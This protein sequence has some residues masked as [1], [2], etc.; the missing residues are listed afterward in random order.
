MLSRGEMDRIH[1][2]SIRILH[3]TGAIVRSADA[4]GLLRNAGN[5]V[6]EKEMRVF[7]EE[8]LIK[9]ALTSAPREIVLGAR[10]PKHDLRV[11]NDGFPY[12]STDGFAVQIRDSETFERRPSIREDLKKWATVTDALDAIDVLWPSIGA[13]DLPPQTQLLGS[14][15]TVL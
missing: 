12:M 4:R 3:E 8:S 5:R 6:V 13:T 11:P 9:D 1:D 14:L 2:A 10:N 7:F 15:R